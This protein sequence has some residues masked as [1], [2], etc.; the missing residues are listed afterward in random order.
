MVDPQELFLISANKTILF[1]EDDSILRQ[2]AKIM[3]K[4]LFDLVD[5]AQDGL[6]ALE[7]Y[8]DYYHRHHKYYDI[9]ISDIKM[10]LMDGIELTKQ[11]YDL[12]KDQRVMIIS[13]HDDSHYLIELINLGIESFIQ[14][15]FTTADI[16]SKIYSV[17]QEIE[18]S[19]LKEVIA[20][21]DNYIWCH[22]E[23]CIRHHD[24]EIKLTKNEKRLL[25]L[26]FSNPMKTF[27]AHELYEFIGKES[28]EECNINS[29]KSLIK[30]LRKKI[31]SPLIEN[32][33]AQGYKI[34]SAML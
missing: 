27:K 4:E 11:I 29:L 2:S 1:V 32:V 16:L 20:L 34:N 33:Y 9:V 28:D 23:Q 25:Y 24:Q 6:D 5:T 21:K 14:K 19:A 8:Q 17:C 3:F 13:A 18:S 12:N 30:R 31:P 10:P 15:P 22:N 26:L 7:K